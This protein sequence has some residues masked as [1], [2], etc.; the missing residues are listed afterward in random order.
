MTTAFRQLRQTAGRLKRPLRLMT[1]RLKVGQLK[2]L[3]ADRLKRLMVERLTVDRLK[4]LTADRL[5]WLQPLL[6]LRPSLAAFQRRRPLFH[7][8]ILQLPVTE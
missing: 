2:R 4:R 1:E 7:P 6:V 3:T 5:K 8:T